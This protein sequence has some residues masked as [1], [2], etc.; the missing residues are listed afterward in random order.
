MA[1]FMIAHLQNGRL[2]DQRILSEATAQK[3]HTRVFG[4]DPRLPGFALGFYEKDSHGLHI[5]GHGG[6][7][8]WFHTDLA[9]IPSESLGVF[10]SYNTDTGGSLSYGPFLETFLDHYYPATPAPVALPPDFAREAPKFTGIY[11]STRTSYTTFMKALNLTGATSIEATDSGLIMRS[12]GDPVR[13][14]PIGPSLFRNSITGDLVAFQQDPKGNV[15]HAFVGSEPM[16]ALEKQPASMTPRLHL[17]ILGAGVVLFAWLIIG[18]VRRGIR[19]L[20]GSRE[21]VAPSVRLGRRFLLGAALANLVF[22]A[23]VMNIAGNAIQIILGNH[24]TPV[25]VAL[26]FPVLGALLVLGAIYAAIQQWRRGEGTV[27]SRVRF[28]AM[29]AL[30]VLF[31]WSLNRWNLIGWKM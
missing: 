3:M 30:S 21:T 15:T 31:V 8:Q 12:S 22:V 29:V 19:A 20:R 11:Q 1:K 7:S 24:L 14:A 17:V 2:G 25:K 4:H 6:D 9:L 26:I 27:G 28:S 5:I 23:V 10:V 18:A 13:L 16:T